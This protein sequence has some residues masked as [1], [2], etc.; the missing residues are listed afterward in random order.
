M[1]SWRRRTYK[2]GHQTFY[3]PDE[4]DQRIPL[5]GISARLLEIFA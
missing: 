2:K 3:K 4:P 1:S 5:E